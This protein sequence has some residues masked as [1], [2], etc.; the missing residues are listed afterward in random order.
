M[1]EHMSCQTQHSIHVSCLDSIL[2]CQSSLTTTFMRTELHRIQFSVS[3]YDV[4]LGDLS[5]VIVSVQHTP[6]NR[7]IGKPILLDGVSPCYIWSKKFISAV[8]DVITLNHDMYLN[9]FSLH[10]QFYD[11]LEAYLSASVTVPLKDDRV[12]I[13]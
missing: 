12:Y 1:V 11:E 5:Q 9:W 7:V 6:S 10:H 4:Y 13:T 2:L 3:I 8:W